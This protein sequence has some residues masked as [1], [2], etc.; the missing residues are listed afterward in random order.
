MPW[1]K[2]L[3]VAFIFYY[4]FLALWLRIEPWMAAG[5]IST[6]IVASLTTNW[7]PVTS[8]SVTSLTVTLLTITSLLFHYCF[9][10]F[11]VT[12]YS[13]II[14]FADYGCA[15][16]YLLTASSY[17]F[18]LAPFELC[19]VFLLS[20]SACIE[21]C[22]KSKK[23]RDSSAAQWRISVRPPCWCFFNFSFPLLMSWLFHSMISMCAYVIL[24]SC[25]CSSVFIVFKVVSY[26]SSLA[27]H[28]ETEI[29]PADKLL[30][31]TEMIHLSIFF[32]VHQNALKIVHVYI[33]QCM[34]SVSTSCLLTSIS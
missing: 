30:L 20:V 32:Y 4:N 7:P 27:I 9:I 16:Y 10:D 23:K 1:P 3:P 12:N 31:R 13:L 17:F 28:K 8:L 18:F 19:F 34:L 26:F 33:L 14:Y 5:Q 2:I 21:T 15:D 6:L 11:Y 22:M 24:S 29:V 25:Y